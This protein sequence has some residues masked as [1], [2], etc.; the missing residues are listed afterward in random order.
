MSAPGSIAF[1]ADAKNVAESA[2]AKVLVQSVKTQNALRTSRALELNKAG[3]YE[4]AKELMLSN[5]YFAEGMLSRYAAGFDGDESAAAELRDES[6]WNTSNVDSLGGYLGE[7][8][9]KML[10]TRSTQIE[11]QQAV[12]QEGL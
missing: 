7:R 6:S 8:K 1:I 5:A 9:G 10:R 2:D 4:E 12:Q 11:T 3:R